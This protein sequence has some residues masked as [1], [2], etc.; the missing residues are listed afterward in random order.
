MVEPKK[1]K[2]D[3]AAGNVHDR[4]HVDEVEVK[5]GAKAPAKPKKKAPK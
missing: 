3:P 5:A 4:H 1:P 2:F